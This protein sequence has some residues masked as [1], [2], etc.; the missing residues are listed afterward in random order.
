MRLVVEFVVSF[1]GA[2][3]EFGV[4]LPRA[5]STDGAG[6]GSDARGRVE[7]EVVVGLHEYGEC[8]ALYL[9]GFR[10]FG[11]LYGVRGCANDGA[12]EDLRGL[13]DLECEMVLWDAD[14]DGLSSSCACPE[15]RVGV[16]RG[17]LRLRVIDCSEVGRA[18]SSEA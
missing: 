11:G 4:E 10:V 18:E 15:S 9:G 5:P 8:V 6:L 12:S 7:R 17:Y 14:F 3:A 2:L 13:S 1:N 16:G